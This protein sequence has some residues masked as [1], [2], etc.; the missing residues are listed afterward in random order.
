MTVYVKNLFS[1]KNLQQVQ[2][3]LSRMK[4]HFLEIIN[5]TSYVIQIAAHL[6]QPGI[7]GSSVT[8]SNISL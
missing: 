6:K 1:K 8:L 4:L 5:H 3:L 2:I 7:K